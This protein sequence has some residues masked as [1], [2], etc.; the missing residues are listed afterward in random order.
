MTRSSRRMEAKSG[1]SSVQARAIRVLLDAV[2]VTDVAGVFEDRPGPGPGM[3]PEPAG[4]DRGEDD[5]V[6]AGSGSGA[7]GRWPGGGG[8]R[9]SSRTRAHGSMTPPTLAR[10]A[11]APGRGCGRMGAWPQE[12]SPSTASVPGPPWRWATGTSR[13]S[14]L[15]ALDGLRHRAAPLLVE[16]RPGE[17]A[18]ARGRPARPRRRHRG[19]GQLGLAA[20][21]GDG[22]RHRDRLHPRAGSHAGL[23][24]G[25]GRGRPGRH[26]RRPGGHG[27]GRRPGQPARPR[28]AGDRPLGHRRVLGPGRLLQHQRGDRVPA[29]HRALRAAALGPAGLR[30]LP[31]RPAGNGDLPPGEPGVP[32]P[33][34]LR[35]GRR[36]G[37]PRHP[38]GDRLPH[39]HGQRPGRPR[40]G[41]GRD[42]GRGGHARASP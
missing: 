17:P 9:T 20:G 35:D 4:V 13:I 33:G 6:A 11:V 31:G 7:R 19:G 26:A 14:R 1:W 42:R 38:G 15:G 32:G 25:P 30:R 23:H 36:P 28:R 24:R 2:D 39:H 18:A 27:R 5:R 40:L 3:G 8:P 37:L 22:Q 29:E 41:G 12:R 16:D 21:G 10:A 34:G